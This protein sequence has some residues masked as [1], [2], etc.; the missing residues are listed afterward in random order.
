MLFWLLLRDS[1]GLLDRVPVMFPRG[2]KEEKFS[3]IS[4]SGDDSASEDAGTGLP[5]KP[6]ALGVFLELAN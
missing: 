2:D 5:S 4:L 1:E 6:A 3:P